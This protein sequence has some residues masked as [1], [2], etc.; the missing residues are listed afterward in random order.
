M[1]YR[2]RL[3]IA[4]ALAAAG[5]PAAAQQPARPPAEQQLPEVPVSAERNTSFRSNSV[6]VGTFRDQDPLDVPLTANVVTRE[7]LDA[8]GANTLYGA[9][10]N[11]AGVRIRY[12]F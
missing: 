9:L 10:K 11:T 1:A 12:Q 4:L 2:Q 7:V 8:Q 6:Q 5:G 3:F